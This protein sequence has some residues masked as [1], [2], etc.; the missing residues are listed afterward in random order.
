MNLRPR[1]PQDYWMMETYEEPDTAE[2]KRLATINKW[3]KEHPNDLAILEI[4][5]TTGDPA[6]LQLQQLEPQPLVFN[7]ETGQTDVLVAPVAQRISPLCVG[8]SKRPQTDDARDNFILFAPRKHAL[9]TDPTTG[10]PH[11]PLT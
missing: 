10:G 2:G 5:P 6:S 8:V 4:I 3:V 11:S 9:K 7:P 1:V